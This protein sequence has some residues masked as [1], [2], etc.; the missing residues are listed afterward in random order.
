[1][2]VYSEYFSTIPAKNTFFAGANTPKGF[3]GEYENL[4]SED[5]FLKIYTVK[6]GAGTGKSTLIKKT[7]DTAIS[8][9]AEVVYIRCSSDPDSLDGVIIERGEK[10]IAVID[11]TSPHA[12]DPLYPGACSEIINCGECWNSEVLEKK[13]KSISS[14]IS[15]KKKAYDRAYAFLSA[16]DEVY[17]MQ[18]RL[19]EY[20]M[21]RE[22]MENAIGRFCS[23]LGKSKEKGHTEYRRTCAIS[24]N[25]A[26]RLSSFESAGTLVGVKECGFISPLFY[27]CLHAELK[28][29]G[30]DTVVSMSPVFGIAEI[31]IPKKDLSIIPYRDGI[32]CEKT[33]N[34]RRFAA[35]DKLAKVKQKRIFSSK[36]LTAMIEGALESLEEAKVH[37]FSLEKIYKEAMCF[38]K[39]D[40]LEESLCE[41][42]EKRLS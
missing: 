24:M 41:S 27:E 26:V 11:G 32:G 12:Y 16:A 4:L 22:K 6:G 21:D 7:A 29:S 15:D 25:G 9:G 13:K 39:L 37:H 8:A 38:S 23:S 17:R 33:F 36:C 1:M 35:G 5:K 14:L 19:A 20:C 2:L 31:Y 42:I 10:R 18:R 3:V 40:V 30:F 34:L 28:N